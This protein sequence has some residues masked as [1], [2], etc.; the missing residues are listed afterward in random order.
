MPE[1]PT[2]NTTVKQRTI[3]EKWIK[4]NKVGIKINLNSISRIIKGSI[5]IKENAKDLSNMVKKQFT[6][7]DKAVGASLISRLLSMKYVG[8]LRVKTTHLYN[9]AHSVKIEGHE[10]VWSVY[11]PVYFLILFL[12]LLEPLR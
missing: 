5:E 11:S 1:K 9:S 2:E 6:I 3:Y 4:A 12:L 8:T 10:C 7:T